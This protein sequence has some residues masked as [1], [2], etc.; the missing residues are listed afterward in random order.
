MVYFGL[1]GAKNG[2]RGLPPWSKR[3]VS[4]ASVQWCLHAAYDLDFKGSIGNGH[5]LFQF[6]ALYEMR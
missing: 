2:L 3:L 5:V 6:L 4:F 1:S